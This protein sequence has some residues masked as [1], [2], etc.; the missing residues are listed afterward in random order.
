MKKLTICA[1]AIL[2]SIAA[3]STANAENMSQSKFQH[4]DKNL[5]N[6]HKVAKA[7]CETLADN[8][9]DI[10]EAEADGA[11]DISKAELKASYKPTIENRYDANMI[12][13]DVNFEVANEKC[14]S[15]KDSEEV[16]CE[17]TAKNIHARETANARTQRN[18][19]KTDAVK[20]DKTANLEELNSKNNP[21]ISYNF[22]K[23]YYVKT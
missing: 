6:E 23:P 12:K 3:I 21:F 5:N 11:R 13:A 9:E 17:K 22:K 14:D 18:I 7:R 4:L 10:C 19:E 1:T 8:A 20:K 15:L 16:A 2:F